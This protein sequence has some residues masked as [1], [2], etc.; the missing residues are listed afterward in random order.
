ML[1]GSGDFRHWLGG[2]GVGSLR[3]EWH[4]DWQGVAMKRY[5]WMLVAVA[6]L[7]MPAWAQARNLGTLEFSPCTLTS[8]SAPRP[9]EAYC[10]SLSVPEDRSQPQG[11][12]IELAL[13]WI[14]PD[15]GDAEPDPVFLLAGGPG[16]SARESYPMVAPAFADVARSRNIILLDQR[17]T[18]GSNLLQCEQDEDE[19]LLD[20]DTEKLRELARECVQAL[21]ARADLRHYTTTDAV[22]DLDAV[23]EAIGAEK[24]NLVGVS[25]GTRVAQQYAKAHP[26]AVRSLVL[27]GVVPT[28]LALGQEHARNLDA[29]LALQFER[30]TRLEACKAMGDPRRN[31]HQAAQALRENP[32][33]VRYRDATGGELRE[34]LLNAQ[35]LSG[36]VRMYAYQPGTA[37]T[38][39]LLL[40]QAVQQQDDAVLAQARMLQRS[41]GDSMAQG[42]AFSVSCSEDADEL[43]PDP[44]DAGTV[45]GP[46]FI[47]QTLALCAPWPRGSRPADFREP[48]RADLPAL[49]LS[50]EFDPVTPPRYGEAVAGHL[51]QARHLVLRG[52]GHNVIVAGCMPKLMARF[53]ERPEPQALD[54]ECLERLDY[55]PPFVGQYGW[56]P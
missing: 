33:T 17:G 54:V 7:C 11:R 31:Y 22:A 6:A 1:P 40:H 26:Q 27:D 46:D 10:T 47:E 18:G 19:D 38:L 24:I 43:K 13:A 34:D 42:M 36:L 50:G 14:A 55:T 3:A 32:R 5:G 56:E 15:T 39:P 51:P 12:H 16:Q 41:M 9:T 48:L 53:I 35:M 23:R 25:Y 52:Q 21:S 29:A 20:A 28:T 49:L 4:Q 37:A 45:L 30:C 2:V 8:A 44:T